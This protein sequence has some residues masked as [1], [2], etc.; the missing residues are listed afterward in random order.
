[1]C[2]G[3]VEVFHAHRWGTVCDDTWDL[4]A[5]Q[6]TCRYLGCGHALRAPGHAHFGEG[7]GP[8]WLDG[9]ECTGKEEGLAQCHLHTWGEHNCG[10]GEDAGVVCTDSPVAPSPSRC[11]PP[12]PPGETPPGQ[13]QVRLVNGSHTCAGRVEVFH[14]HRWG[15]V[16]DD[17]WDL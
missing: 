4:A 1:T 5:A 7:T 13:V 17:T 8:I 11:A 10:H 3:R 16:C 14:A 9:T 2:A 15:T 6:V 12:V